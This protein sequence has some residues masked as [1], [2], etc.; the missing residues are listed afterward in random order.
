MHT[1]QSIFAVYVTQSSKNV[2]FL[3]L[4]STNILLTVINDCDFSPNQDAFSPAPSPS[5]ISHTT[6]QKFLKEGKS[7]SEATF[8]KTMTQNILNY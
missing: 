8:E 3:L 2:S 7:L 6:P 5:S 1:R 4:E